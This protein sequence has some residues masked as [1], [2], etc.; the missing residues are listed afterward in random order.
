[1]CGNK[2]SICCMCTSVAICHCN[3]LVVWICWVLRSVNYSVDESNACDI[4]LESS[5]KQFNQSSGTKGSRAHSLREWG[6]VTEGG[7]LGGTPFSV[8]W[9]SSGNSMSVV[10]TSKPIPGKDVE[11]TI[12][13]L[14]Q[15]IPKTIGLAWTLSHSLGGWGKKSWGWTRL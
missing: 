12:Q 5:S 7:G 4:G 14:H 8:T 1:M 15:I 6:L 10:G 3:H 11:E 9:R 13:E 2:D